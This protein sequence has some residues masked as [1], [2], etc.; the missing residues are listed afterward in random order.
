VGD[1]IKSA[2]PAATKVAALGEDAYNT[3]QN[4]YRIAL[5]LANPATSTPDAL[6]AYVTDV[7]ISIN[8]NVTPNK[9]IGVLGAFDTSA[10]NFE[11]SGSIT[12]YFT[13]V[14]AVRAVRNNADVSLYTI[15]AAKNAGFVFDIPLL[16]LGGG[17]V[18]VEKDQPIQVPVEPAGA[19]NKFGYTMAYVR[20][21][22]LPSI[23]MP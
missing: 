16:G 2:D 22:Y 7:S 1:E 12:A 19:Q 6:F 3:S 13:T 4:I 8:N 9:A 17:R 10:G 5:S 23:A 15:S 20:F 21:N 18:T 11:V 14:E